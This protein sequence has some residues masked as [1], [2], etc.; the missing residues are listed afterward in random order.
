MKYIHF[1]FSKAIR[2]KEILSCLATGVR[3][4]ESYPEHVRNFCIGLNNTSPTGYRF[5]RHVFDDRIPAPPTIRTWYNNSDINCEPG[6]MQYS[7]NVLKRIV[8]DMGLSGK[9]F[10][11]CLLFDEMSIHKMVQFV[12]SEMI[13]FETIPGVEKKCSN[14]VTSVGI[15]V[16]WY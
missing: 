14:S 6:I 8:R 11:G 16:K 12:G 10:V 3:H 4:G 2:Q 5:C 13:G 15:H 7:L 9:T 1:Q